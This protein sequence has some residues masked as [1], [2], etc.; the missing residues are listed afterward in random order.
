MRSWRVLCLVLFLSLQFSWA[1]VAGYCQHQSDLAPT[2]FGHHE[3]D[4]GPTESPTP[5]SAKVAADGDG[6][7]APGVDA[8]CVA[9]HAACASALPWCPE[10][11]PL[12]RASAAVAYH[13]VRWPAP[14]GQ[15]LDRPQWLLPA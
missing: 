4:H 14:P 7:G 6:T 8:D 5:L 12:R 11:S 1:A 10:L 15:R 13:P 3:H 9:C 2:H